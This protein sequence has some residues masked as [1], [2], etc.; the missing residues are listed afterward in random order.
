MPRGYYWCYCCCQHHYHHFFLHS[1][2]D[3]SHHQIV[4]LE[5]LFTL[6]TEPACVAYVSMNVTSAFNCKRCFSMSDT[7]KYYGNIQPYLTTLMP[8]CKMCSMQHSAIAIFGNRD[9]NSFFFLFC[10]VSAPIQLIA[11][12]S[13]FVVGVCLNAFINAKLIFMPE[14]NSCVKF[15]FF[16]FVNSTR[17]IYIFSI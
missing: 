14:H 11:F 6:A 3:F 9:S 4:S 2:S 5:N 1:F 15:K 16:F 12:A 7:M 10:F 13:V 17:T 8:L